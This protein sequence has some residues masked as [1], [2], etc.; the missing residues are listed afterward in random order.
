[1]LPKNLESPL[2]DLKVLLVHEKNKKSLVSLREDAET[3]YIS[4]RG[5]VDRQ[6]HDNP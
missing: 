5:S 3:A 1:M 4:F 6:I 2:N